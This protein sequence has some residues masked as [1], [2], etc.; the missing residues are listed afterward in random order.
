MKPLTDGIAESFP[1]EPDALRAMLRMLERCALNI[2]HGT[3][4]A[5]A[6][7]AVQEAILKTFKRLDQIKY[8]LRYLSRAT[9]FTALNHLKK[10]NREVSLDEA[11]ELPMEIADEGRVVTKEQAAAIITLLDIFEPIVRNISEYDLA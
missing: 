3:R 1:T 6:Q 4:E 10:Q 9:K 5:D 2:F 8:P 11:R 7:D